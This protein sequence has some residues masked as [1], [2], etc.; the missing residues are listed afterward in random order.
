V[1][2]GGKKRNALIAFAGTVV[3]GI[4][5]IATSKTPVLPLAFAAIA[6]ILLVFTAVLVYQWRHDGAQGQ[7]GGSSRPAPVTDLHPER[8][9]SQLDQTQ[10]ETIDLAMSGAVNDVANV[11]GMPAALVRSNLFARIPGTDELGMVKE[12]W[13][14]M[15]RPQEWTVKMDIGQGST[16]I[17]WQT[18]DANRVIWD[19]GWGESEIGDDTE[20][21]KIHPELR[22]IL[23]VPI[24]GSR[25]PGTKLILNVDG[26]QR[27]PDPDHLAAALGHLP[28]FGQGI[29]RVLG[30]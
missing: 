1:S 8:I 9:A 29:S 7:G 25:G 23:T 20:L 16:G 21:R 17:A 2:D 15:D 24:F 27:T 5:A 10:R 6:A 30:L 4:V 12:L 28:R 11:V 19:G 22:W 18:G 13:F 26:L 3:S 14:H